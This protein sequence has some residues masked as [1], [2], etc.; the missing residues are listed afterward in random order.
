M[1]G[2]ATT[3]G[4]PLHL[5]K[6]I[7]DI[8]MNAYASQSLLY[9]VVANIQDAPKGS[10][11]GYSEAQISPL[12]NLRKKSEGDGLE[13][14]TPVE[15][16]KQTV[17]PDVFAL[18]FRLTKE[19]DFDDLFGNFRKFPKELGKS[20]AYKPEVEFWNLFNYA[21]VTT[22]NTAWDGY[23]L[24]SDSHTT[25]KSEDSIDNDMTDAALSETALQAMFEY[26]DALV[27]EA[28]RPITLNPKYLITGNALRFDSQKL[29]RNYGAIGTANNDLNTVNPQHSIVGPY[30]IINTPQISSTTAFFL[31][32]KEHDLRL[33]WLWRTVL[34]AW[35][36]PYTLSRLY[37]VNQR[38]MTFFMDY[39]GVVGNSGL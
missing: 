27:D 10:G 35:D 19:T 5:D 30:E 7:Y 12:G 36:D 24:C 1:A 33:W 9:P 17:T 2:I 13:F 20:A 14:D 3:L 39:K 4:F 31:V 37:A 8:W 15:G 11:G 32:A 18:G 22:Y 6:E 21:F 38:F 28:G 34:Q 23:A 25:L 26:Y 16:D 29:M